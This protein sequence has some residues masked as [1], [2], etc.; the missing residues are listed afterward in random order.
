VR[1]E[2]DSIRLRSPSCDT[3]LQIASCISVGIVANVGVG[4]RVA[5]C[6]FDCK[7]DLKDS[8]EFEEDDDC[9]P[10]VVLRLLLALIGNI[11]AWISWTGVSR[12][13]AGALVFMS[14]KCYGHSL[15]QDLIGMGGGERI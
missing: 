12:S 10:G 13:L 3:N 4:A 14:N 1:L 2:L 5:L 8:G 11:R 15:R 9:V 7:S 6:L